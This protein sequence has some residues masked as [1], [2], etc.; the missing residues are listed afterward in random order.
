MMEQMVA[1]R[2]HGGAWKLCRPRLAIWVRLGCALFAVLLFAAPSALASDEPR[3]VAARTDGGLVPGAR[4]LRVTT[5][6]NEGP[7]S[8]RAALTAQGPRVVVFE[9]GGVIDL[10]SRIEVTSPGLTVAGQTAPDPGIVVRGAGLVVRT[11]DVR[12]EH[13]GIYPGPA[14]GGMDPRSIDALALISRATSRQEVRR[15]VLRNLTLAHA[16]DE[17]LSF[18]GDA[19]GAIRLESS[20]VAKGLQEAGHPRVQHSMGLLIYQDIE[21]LSVV[22]NIFANNDRRNPVVP[23]GVHGVIANNLVF[24]HGRN[25]IHVQRGSTGLDLRAAIFGNV[26]Q[27]NMATTCGLHTIQVPLQVFQDA[28]GARLFLD[29]NLLDTRF[30]TS[31]ECSIPAPLP[32]AV[33]ERLA[34]LPPASDPEWPRLP[35]AELRGFVLR[36]AG[37]RPAAR[38]AMDALILRGITEGIGRIIN[39]PEDDGGWP[40]IAPSRGGMPADLPATLADAAAVARLA[41]ALCSRHRAVGG[42][43]NGD[44]PGAPPR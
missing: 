24:G 6:G 15:V 21:N 7:G 25:S 36:H 29:D 44:C 34:P 13:L 37:S 18:A 2:H 40:A 41:A 33:R 32:A 28:P 20:L 17:N 39:T 31:P 26:V 22:G 16:T 10:T 38:N 27:P 11:S 1:M 14:R 35:A 5:L 19:I 8:L 9:V 42:P 12:L 3:P 43:P 30:V 23:A 4:I